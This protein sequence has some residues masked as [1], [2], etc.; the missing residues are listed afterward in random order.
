VSTLTS[1]HDGVQLEND[2]GNQGA[3]SDGGALICNGVVLWDAQAVP[4]GAGEC[5]LRDVGLPP[6]EWPN[7]GPGYARVPVTFTT[8]TDSPAPNEVAAALTCVRA[9]CSDAVFAVLIA[10]YCKSNNGTFQ[11]EVVLPQ[12]AHGCGTQGCDEHACPR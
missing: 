12:G 4:V 8:P 7:V 10:Q 9:I 5:L 6:P 3:S 11:F 2:A 1:T